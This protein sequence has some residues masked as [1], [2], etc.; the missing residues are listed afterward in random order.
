MIKNLNFYDICHEHLSYYSI[1][2]FERLISQFNLKIFYAETNGVNGG[3]IR[4]YVCKKNCNKYNTFNDFFIKM[5]QFRFI[6]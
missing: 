1:Y 2:S 3:S 4:F 6:T 5:E